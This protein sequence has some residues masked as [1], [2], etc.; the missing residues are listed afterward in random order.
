MIDTKYISVS[1][2]IRYDVQ[3]VMNALT[4]LGI[5]ENPTIDD[6]IEMIEKW[7]RDD[8]SC[9]YGHEADLT[10]LVFT[11]DNGNEL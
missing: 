1:K 6:A 10:E 9:G 4:E 5:N 2:T 11:D 8:F 3:D 7:C